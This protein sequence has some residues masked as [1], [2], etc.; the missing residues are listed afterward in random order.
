MKIIT[1]LQWS[2]N[3]QFIFDMVDRSI[4]PRS[5]S[6]MIQND[7]E[8]LTAKELELAKLLRLKYRPLIRELTVE[9]LEYFYFTILYN[10]LGLSGRYTL[11]ELIE[12]FNK[13]YPNEWIP[14]NH[15]PIVADIQLNL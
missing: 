5:S 13:L 6:G 15:L 8:I 4:I 11:D 12:L 1:I 14:S 3:G 9:S 7:H 2:I 10:Q